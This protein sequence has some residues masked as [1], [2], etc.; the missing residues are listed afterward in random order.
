M[1][2]YDFSVFW[3]TGLAILQGH[4][5][6]SVQNS[7]YPP[8][9]A[10]LYTLFA[11]LPF[12][13]AFP[14]WCGLNVLFLVDTLRRKRMIRQ[15]PAWL[16]SAP[17]LFLLLSGQIDLLFLW[18]ANFM[19]G[20]GW[21]AALAAA[22]ITLKPQT[23]LIL[24]PWLLLGWLR[25]ERVQLLRWGGLCL[26]LHGYPLLFDPG[27]YSRWLAVVA[28]QTSWRPTISS[29]LFLLTNIN[30]P[31]WAIALPALAVAIW[32]LTRDELT[33]RTALVLAQPVAIWYADI[34]LV[35]A[36]SW[37]VFLPLTLA[38][39]AV[40]VWAN[41]SLPFLVIPLVVLGVRVYK[42]KQAVI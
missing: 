32:G 37:K 16:G 10:Y 3:Q 17:S 21:P 11:L 33:A 5:P 26:L 36:I 24:L 27:I 1:L 20:R 42:S 15:L 41:N 29:G 38:A 31:V 35:G 9:M 23:A 6:Y 40:S 12:G 34:L 19:G 22:L 28:Q 25:T 4:D 39:F 13:L 8:G 7:A 14:L 30:V 18:L 2:G